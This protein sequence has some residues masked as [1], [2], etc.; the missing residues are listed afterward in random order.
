VPATADAALAAPVRASAHIGHVNLWLGIFCA[1]SRSPKGY[2]EKLLDLAH[3]RRQPWLPRA[4]AM[5]TVILLAG[6]GGFAWDE[7]TVRLARMDAPAA[8]IAVLAAQ[9]AAN[10]VKQFND[11]LLAITYQQQAPALRGVDPQARD[12]PLFEALQREAYFAFVDVLDRNGQ[13]VAGL[14]HDSNNW[15]D[16]DYFGALE[17]G[18]SPDLFI[19][20]RFSVDNEQA[21][22]I[23]V[24]RRIADDEGNFDGL[25]VLGVRLAHFRELLNK[26][27]LA[28][29]QSITLMSKDGT[30]LSRVPARANAIGNK[31][32]PESPLDTA[33]RSG[34]TLV[35]TSDPIDHLERRFVLR[36]VGV[37][38]LIV[39]VGTQTSGPFASLFLWWLVICGSG[40]LARLWW[41]QGLVARSPGPAPVG[42][43][44]SR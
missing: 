29:D 23:T 39:A 25:V 18:R 38:P 27:V 20:G 4:A 42:A 7:D 24:S 43:A 3:M 26:L 15:S 22:G 2:E 34:R 8:N 13:A 16:R 32:D 14:P 9:D 41:R 12:A 37:Y 10:S 33:L 1:H 36:P 11:R 35:V 19:G 31:L 6:I 30:V 21:V 28:P 44:D 17:H 5:L 40:V